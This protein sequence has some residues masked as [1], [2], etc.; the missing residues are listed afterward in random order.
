MGCGCSH[1]VIKAYETCNKDM[2]G[3]EELE[4]LA[5]LPERAKNEDSDLFSSLEISVKCKDL[6]LSGIDAIVYFLIEE[7]NGFKVQ[8]QTEIQANSSDPMF[9]TTF[10]ISYSFEKHLRFK[11]DLYDNKL[12]N[13]D[14]PNRAALV[15]TAVFNVHEVVCS[16]S[17]SVCKP[18]LNPL[19]RNKDIGCIWA[20]SEQNSLS[21]SEVEMVWELQGTEVGNKYL[22]RLYRHSDGEAIPVYQTESIK[23]ASSPNIWQKISISLN[24]LCKSDVHKTLLAEIFQVN[25]QLNLIGSCY[26]T[27]HQLKSNDFQ[28]TIMKG[29]VVKGTIKLKLFNYIE[30]HSFLEYILGGCEISLIIGIDFTKSNGNPDNETSLHYLNP[31]RPND[32]IQAIESVGEI[33]QYYDSDKKFPVYGF[34]AKMP[35]KFEIVSHC[36]ALNKNFFDP[37]ISGIQNIISEYSKIVKAVQMHG[38]TCFSEI[39]NMACKYASCV[40]ISQEKQQYFVLLIITDG[41]IN[42]L[43]QTVDEIAYAS[44]LPISIVIVG[45]GNEDF[46]MMKVLDADSSPLFS[47]KYNMNITK[48]IIQFVPFKDF[49]SKPY[50]LAKE[51]LYEIPTQ[52]LDFMK[53][54]NLKPGRKNLKSLNSLSGQSK[55]STASKL[56]L[57]TV[58]RKFIQDLVDLGYS[59]RIV[60]DV[61]N[62]GIICMD[63]D[64]VIDTI[65]GLEAK[66]LDKG[67]VNTSI[68]KSKTLVV[69]NSIKKFCYLCQINKINVIV[70][71]CG[72]E[73]VCSKC[74]KNIGHTCPV[75]GSVIVKWKLKMSNY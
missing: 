70:Q 43:E 61:I 1:K 69:E 38:P 6:R 60:K 32:Y 53:R 51:V 12:I 71:D 7:E 8:S 41:I 67:V 52:F 63:M 74:V 23:M 21:L 36:F 40:E 56:F 62:Q 54:K 10:N 42:D 9:I 45:V 46:S 13:E 31:Q 3:Y 16:P 18:L 29:N 24:K 57:D 73:V 58:K 39:I 50:E 5:K 26:F 34:G 14:P 28:A 30:K 65:K 22:M 55:T 68:N 44:T 64:I 47:K 27:A 49:K 66:K 35:S 33:L 75:C 17:H 72:C 15:G 2:K 48:D 20:H 19:C 11:L 25:K 59:K 37:E 4:E